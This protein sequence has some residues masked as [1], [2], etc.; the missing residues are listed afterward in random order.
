[1]RVLIETFR[2]N[3]VKFAANVDSAVKAAQ[4]GEPEVAASAARR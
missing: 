3:L 2:K 1:M 4:P